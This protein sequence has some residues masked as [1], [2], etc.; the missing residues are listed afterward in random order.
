MTMAP[1]FR[2]CCSWM[3]TTARGP[4]RHFALRAHSVSWEA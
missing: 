3:F 2:R 1:T 4:L